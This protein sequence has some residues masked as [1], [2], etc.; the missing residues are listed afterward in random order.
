[1]SDTIT[2]AE[3]KKEM[4]R[5]K[6]LMD[7]RTYFKLFPPRPNYIYGRHTYG[8]IKAFQNAL[9]RVERGESVY[10]NI[11]V[12]FRH[13][14]SDISSRRA[15]SWILNRNP[16]WEVMLISYAAEL[17]TDFSYAS[18]N[19]F[20]HSGPL[21]GNFLAQDMAARGKWKT[22]QGGGMYAAGLGGS[23]TGKGA[24]A[25]IIDDYCKNRMDAE[26][27]NERDKAWASFTNDIMTRLAPIHLVCVTA[28]R[29]GS[30]DLVARIQNRNNPKHKDYDEDFPVFEN[31]VF[32]ME[33]EYGKNDW[34]FPE[35]FPEKWYRAQRSTLGKYGY[36]SLGLQDPTERTGNMLHAELVVELE[37]DEWEA[38]IKDVP[39]TR[40][41]DLASTA[42]ELI[43]DDPDYTVGTKAAFHKNEILVADVLRGQWST[44]KRNK[45]IKTAAQGDGIN[46]PVHVEAV[47]GYVDTF[48]TIKENL[49]GIAKVKKKN[50]DGD[51][52]SRATN[53][54]E[55]IFEISRVFVPKGAPWLT[56]WYSEFKRFPKGHDDQV[57]SLMV[58]IYDKIVK[59]NRMS[60][61][62]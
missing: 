19:H 8:I 49:K 61:S 50:P 42:K 23:I 31:I 43:K 9:E 5:R 47:A 27:E 4:V 29:W 45:I 57:D 20:G 56:E 54:I 7:F 13:G 46:V 15:P 14:K 40:G 28:T 38:K 22:D 2:L 3:V 17:A 48:N 39:F 59:N 53:S 1:M 58:A 36:S 60:F 11:S 25:L 37:P 35:R 24:H 10:L 55:P 41:W 16:D 30:D 51:K 52:V 6:A 33:S 34:L 32:G 62:T 44:L 12:P 18:R 21:F 26:N